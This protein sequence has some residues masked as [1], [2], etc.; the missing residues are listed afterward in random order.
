MRLVLWITFLL[1]LAIMWIR[2]ISQY[3]QARRTKPDAGRDMRRFKRRTLGLVLL[4][5]LGLTY[6]LSSV[7]IM[8]GAGQAT[9]TQLR[10]ELMYY[11]IFFLLFVALLIL[12]VRDFRDVAE[13]YLDDQQQMTL[14][15]LTDLDRELKARRQSDSDDQAIPRIEFPGK[16]SDS[17]ANNP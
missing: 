17:D 8:Q 2:E 9:A 13:D 14:Q 4:L 12:A 5:M 7:L 10:W 1:L 15:T 16:E 11:L 6:D 3:V